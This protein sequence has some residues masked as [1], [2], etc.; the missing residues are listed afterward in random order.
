MTFKF[1]GNKKII[2]KAF[3]LTAGLALFLLF[4]KISLERETEILTYPSKVTISER[5]LAS[6]S[7]IFNIKPA[8]KIEIDLSKQKIKLFEGKKIVSEFS[9]STGADETPT[10]TGRFK[11]YSKSVMVYSK[12][13]NCWLPFWA[14]FTS[15]GMYGFH[16]VPICKEGRKGLEVLGKPASIGCVRLGIGDSESFYKWVE[17][18]TPVVIYD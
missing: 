18:G 17:I 2:F 4:T 14:A 6:V 16:E 1:L 9:V 13:S 7:Q 15:D 5:F 3:C 11:V 12:I 10:P 8:K